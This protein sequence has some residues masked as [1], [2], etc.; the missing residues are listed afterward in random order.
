MSLAAALQRYAVVA[1]SW[2]ARRRGLYA[3]VCVSKLPDRLNP[4]T[5]YVVG[6]GSHQWFAGFLCPCGC[7]ET[8]QASL[9]E[10]SRPH[11][12]IALRWDG[13]VSLYPSVWRIKGCRS[14]FWLRRGRVQWC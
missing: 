12:R 3:T 6:E 2:F 1:A 8:I 5:V 13:A 4:R 14:H 11:W 10:K 9:V 7:G